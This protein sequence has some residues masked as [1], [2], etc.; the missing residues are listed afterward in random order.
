MALKDQLHV[1]VVHNVSLEERIEQRKAKVEYLFVEHAFYVSDSTTFLQWNDA[2]TSTRP[3]VFA[4]HIQ[5]HSKL[6]LRS[7]ML[8]SQ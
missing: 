1:F 4:G 8:K 2:T 7:W 5:L 3:S 6:Y